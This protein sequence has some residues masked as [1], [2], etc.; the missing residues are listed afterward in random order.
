MN[1]IFLYFY[2]STIDVYHSHMKI[3][4]MQQAATQVVRQIRIAV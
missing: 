3:R 1:F 2:T 4:C